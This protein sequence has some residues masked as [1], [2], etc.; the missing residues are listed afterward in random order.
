MA[1]IKRVSYRAGFV[2]RLPEARHLTVA[3][4]DAADLL[5]D[6]LALLDPHL[7]A[8]GGTYGDPNASDPLQYDELRIEHEH[9]EVR[10]VVYNRAILLFTA[11]SEAVR[12]IHQV[13]CR[14][15][16]LPQLRAR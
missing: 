11:G 6:M 9:G 13:C 14:F 10:I 5:S 3:T 2:A 1:Q 4:M 15:D 12:R 8:L 16:D 7:L